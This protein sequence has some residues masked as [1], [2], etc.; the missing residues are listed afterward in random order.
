VRRQGFD[1][2]DDRHDDQDDVDDNRVDLYPARQALL[3]RLAMLQQDVRQPS[4]RRD[5]DHDHH[6]DDLHD[7]RL[8][9]AREAV[10]P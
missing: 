3:G 6:H 10:F 2:D 5:L 4:L 1:H 7:H 8:Y 9:Q